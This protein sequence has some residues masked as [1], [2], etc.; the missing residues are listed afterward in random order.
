MTHK[1]LSFLLLLFYVICMGCSDSG[2]NKTKSRDFLPR[3][4]LVPHELLVVMDSTQWKGIL[5]ESIRDVFAEPIAGLPQ[6]EPQFTVRHIQPK[7]LTGIMKRYP[8]I[9]FVFTLDNNRRS[10]Q[11]MQ[12]MFS[13]KALEQIK[14]DPK[15]Y[16]LTRQDEFAKGQEVMYLF[17]SN[18]DQLISRIY[19]SKDALLNYFREVERNRYMR[20]FASIKVSKPI[21]NTLR[22][23]YGFSLN[24]PAGYEIAVQDSNFVWVRL[25]DNKVDKS[26]WVT[27]KPYR[28]QS[29]FERENLLQFRNSVAK[30]YIWGNDSTTYMRL[31]R[32]LPVDIKEVNFKGQYAVE[33][34]GLWRLENMAMGGPF[35]GYAFVDKA[36]D[37]V[38]YIEGFTYAPGQKKRE[39]VSEL[40]AI[41]WS[42]TSHENQ[43]Q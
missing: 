26:V 37:R 23:Q 31:E 7:D 1:P 43:P 20:E 10:T 38:Y 34:R 4:S 24:F 18:E 3:A 35:L 29:I 13:Q 17:G 42:F 15:R 41:L 8:N 14:E 39:A 22:E 19:S 30:K 36:K 11:M 6:D 16:M 40:E 33:A 28:D 9:L 27:W 2:E 25:L 21:T 12:T 5:G 32:D